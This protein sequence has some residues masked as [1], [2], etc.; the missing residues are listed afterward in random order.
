MR[1]KAAEKPLHSKGHHRLDEAYGM[2]RDF[3]NRTLDKRLVSE[4]TLKKLDVEKI[5]H[6]T[7][8]LGH[9]SK[10]DPQKMKH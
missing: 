10:Q 2:G 3:T 4:T 8:N 9:I 6:S 1:P 7:E 5:N